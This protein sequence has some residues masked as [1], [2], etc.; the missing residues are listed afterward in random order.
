[1][2]LTAGSFAQHLDASLCIA[3]G[4]FQLALVRVGGRIWATNWRHQRRTI[5]SLAN[6]LSLGRVSRVSFTY[7]AEA[8]QHPSA[9]CQAG[10]EREENVRIDISNIQSD[11]C[12]LSQ[13]QAQWSRR[14][15]TTSLNILQLNTLM[16]VRLVFHL[17]CMNWL[18]MDKL[19]LSDTHFREVIMSEC[20]QILC[21]NTRQTR[22]NSFISI[23]TSHGVFV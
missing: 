23:C 22:L 1:M 10:R 13:F 9:A 15:L 8:T 16:G 11:Y 4:F 3:L 14:H 2:V 19:K 21:C 12:F 6:T 20:N 18:C 17:F 5:P 7:S